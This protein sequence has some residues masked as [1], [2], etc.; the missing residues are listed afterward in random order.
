MRYVYLL[1]SESFADAHQPASAVPDWKVRTGPSPRRGA[2][3][4]RIG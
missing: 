4:R 1:Q 2:T 3:G